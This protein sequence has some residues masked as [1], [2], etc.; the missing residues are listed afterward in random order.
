MLF[1]SENAPN[2][3]AATVALREGADAAAQKNIADLSTNTETTLQNLAKYTG[4]PPMTTAQTQQATAEITA[5]IAVVTSGVPEDLLNRSL[6]NR[7]ST[8]EQNPNANLNTDSE[9]SSAT[10][11]QTV[12]YDAPTDWGEA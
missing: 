5:G 6:Q 2:P 1:R 11:Q 8:L 3:A 12:G 9:Y 7:S 4:A 10:N